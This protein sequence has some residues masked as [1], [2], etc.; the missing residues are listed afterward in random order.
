LGYLQC[1]PYEAAVVKREARDGR[2]QVAIDALRAARKRAHLSQTELAQKLG[3]RQ[4]FVSKY[5]SGE[6]RLDVIEFLDVATA[7]GL[8][9][10]SLLRNTGLDDGGRKA[11]P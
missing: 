3:R 8:K 4:Q 10:E 6:R 5:E 7:L 9:M 11:M 2:Y 1:P